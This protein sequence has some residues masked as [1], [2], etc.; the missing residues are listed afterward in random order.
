M[1]SPKRP[2]SSR[3]S[4]VPRWRQTLKN[5][6]SSSA[7]SRRMMIDSPAISR[8]M[9]SPGFASPE[10]RPTQFHP[11]AKMRSRSSARIASEV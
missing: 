6:R 10:A 2:D 9:K 8:V 11:R 7:R 5:A 1:V 3:Q 4:R